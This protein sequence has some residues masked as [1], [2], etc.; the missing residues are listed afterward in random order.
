MKITELHN[1]DSSALALSEVRVD[2]LDTYHM[3][4]K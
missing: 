4:P 3:I 1:L 2:I